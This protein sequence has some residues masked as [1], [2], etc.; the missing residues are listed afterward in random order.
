[1]FY[2]SVT[3]MFISIKNVTKVALHE[4]GGNFFFVTITVIRSHIQNIAPP[5]VKDKSSSTGLPLE[6]YM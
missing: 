3:Q 1:M 4:R 5:F 2:L 6:T